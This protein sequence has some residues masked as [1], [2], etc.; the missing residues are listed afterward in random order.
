MIFVYFLLQT[1]ISNLFSVDNGRGEVSSIRGVGRRLPQ[2]IIIGTRKS[3]TRALLRF[4]E[5]NPAVRSPNKE[6]HFFDR[7]SNYE[8]GIEWYRNQMPE[9]GP[10]EITIEKS[11]AY[12]VTHEVPERVKAMNASI[13]L[14]LI[15][16]NPV[17]RLISDFSQTIANRLDDP[18]APDD[19]DHDDHNRAIQMEGPSASNGNVTSTLLW[20][21]AEQEFKKYIL[22][23]DG[24]IDEQRRIVRIGMYS[25][26]LERWLSIFHRDKFHFVDGE[27]LIKRP[28]EELQKLERFLGLPPVITEEHFVFSPKKGFYCLTNDT[29]SSRHKRNAV[30]TDNSF[31]LVCLGKSKGRRHVAV[32]RDLVDK[33]RD[34]YAPY[35]EYLS[36]MTGVNF[37][38]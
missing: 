29:A 17:T 21:V 24:G 12:F 11:P 35:N 7:N 25:M 27:L 10:H 36:S 9:T 15:L 18:S 1:V 4:L 6:V 28:H 20:R 38:V 19:Y 23:S 2:A 30:V 3:G 8:L 22:R 37:N 26:H 14:I 13:K 31:G 32:D 33:L 16:R 5:I 34:F